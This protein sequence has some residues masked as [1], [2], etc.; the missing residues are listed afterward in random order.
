MASV[1]RYL[2]DLLY[3]TITGRRQASPALTVIV[4]ESDYEHFERLR[5]RSAAACEA[6]ARGI[7][8]LQQNL[9]PK[10]SAQYE[11]CGYFDAGTDAR[12]LQK[13]PDKIKFIQPFPIPRA[14]LTGGIK[15]HIRLAGASKTVS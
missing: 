2:R 8:L 12:P 13:T 14:L 10:Q 5:V 6:H 7:Q 4:T 3:L 9:S 11:Q 1:S 15:C